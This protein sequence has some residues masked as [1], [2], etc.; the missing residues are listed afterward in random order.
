MYELAK[1]GVVG[2]R[3]CCAQQGGSSGLRVG[4]LSL[5]GAYESVVD[6]GEEYGV[7]LSARG[8]DQVFVINVQTDHCAHNRQQSHTGAGRHPGNRRRGGLACRP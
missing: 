3:C 7:V 8:K 5:S 6:A 4:E 2:A 1:G